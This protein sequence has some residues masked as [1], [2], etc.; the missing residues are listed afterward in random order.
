MVSVHNLSRS[1]F[2]ALANNGSKNVSLVQPGTL[3]EDSTEW[4]LPRPQQGQM[5]GAVKIFCIFKSLKF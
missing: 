1:F 4:S 3:N 5:K 2:L